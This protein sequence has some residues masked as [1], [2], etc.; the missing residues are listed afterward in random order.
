MTD[1]GVEEYNFV[2]FDMDFSE[3]SY[4]PTSNDILL[5]SLEDMSDR[6]RIKGSVIQFEGYNPKK[7]LLALLRQKL[8]MRNVLICCIN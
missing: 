8:I 5:Q 3:F 6:E 1:T 4:M 7:A 2:D